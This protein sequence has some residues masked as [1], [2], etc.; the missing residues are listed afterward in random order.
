MINMQRR[1]W[2]QDARF[3]LISKLVSKG[4]LSLDEGAEELEVSPSELEKAMIEAG[5]KVPELA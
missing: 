1:V 3:K 5:Y 2:E 4:K